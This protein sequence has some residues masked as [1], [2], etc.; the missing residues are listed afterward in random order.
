MENNPTLKQV[1]QNKI[2]RG[3]FLK[4]VSLV[5]LS[6]LLFSLGYIASDKGISNQIKSSIKSFFNIETEKSPKDTL[7]EVIKNEEQKIEEDITED[8]AV[9]EENDS[10]Q[11]EIP[12]DTKKTTKPPTPIPTE[13]TTPTL[14]CTQ[15]EYDYATAFIPAAETVYADLYA[16]YQRE[17]AEYQDCMYGQSYSELYAECDS[18]L[19][20]LITDPTSRNNLNIQCVQSHYSDCEINNSSDW[21]ETQMANKLAAI[22]VQKVILDGCY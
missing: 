21:Y 17:I 12:Q 1:I 8:P 3:K 7:P 19:S 10:S 6:L 18:K 9:E 11:E 5:I 14:K 16:S 13:P 22:N 20:S 4:I 15:Y 2:K